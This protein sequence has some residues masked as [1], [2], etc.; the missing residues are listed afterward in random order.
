MKKKE[1]VYMRWSEASKF[2]IG[3]T[4][5]DCQHID[6]FLSHSAVGNWH[7]GIFYEDTLG[8]LKRIAELHGCIL[9]EEIKK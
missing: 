8:K 3:Y 2:Y 6:H 7:E 5:L 9:R 4:V 1:I